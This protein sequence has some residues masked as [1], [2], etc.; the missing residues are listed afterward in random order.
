MART[1]SQKLTLDAFE[2]GLFEDTPPDGKYCNK[3]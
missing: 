3:S 2:T 1:E